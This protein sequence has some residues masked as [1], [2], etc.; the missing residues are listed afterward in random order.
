LACYYSLVACPYFHPGEPFPEDA[1]LRQGRF[2]LGA[3]YKGTCRA[4]PDEAF[5]PDEETLRSFCNFGYG[6]EACPRFPSSSE[7]DAVRFSLVSRPDETMSVVF[8]YERDFAPV[9]HGTLMNG[10]SSGSDC[11]AR[12]AEV[13][14]ANYSRKTRCA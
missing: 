1:H 6:R 5:E 3:A 11:L 2:P 8:V 4:L 7:A 13:F 12:Q 14:A 10:D 9:R